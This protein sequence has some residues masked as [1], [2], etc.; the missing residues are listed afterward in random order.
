M[1]HPTTSPTWYLW[2]ND[3]W[4]PACTLVTWY[5]RLVS[6][7]YGLSAYDAFRIYFMDKHLS[8]PWTL[9]KPFEQ[10][11]LRCIIRRTWILF[12]YFF[13]YA[14]SV[15]L[16]I[17]CSSLKIYWIESSNTYVIA[18]KSPS[19]FVASQ[20]IAGRAV[21]LCPTDSHRASCQH[22]ELEVPL[23]ATD[24]VMF[25]NAICSEV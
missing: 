4:I 16:I 18:V 1:K 12:F 23:S 8:L 17:N 21:S 6:I 7:I 3:S 22:L 11:Y 19:R 25:L 2:P 14:S 15:S 20:H 5:L 9:S 13:V 10:I 24:C